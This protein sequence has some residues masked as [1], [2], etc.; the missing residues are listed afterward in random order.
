MDRAR[1][2]GTNFSGADL[3]YAEFLHADISGADFSGASLYRARF[4]KTKEEG[5][6]FTN[7]SAALGDDEKLAEAEDFQPAV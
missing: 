3:T 7:R 2:E 5:V 4:H 1:C 6:I